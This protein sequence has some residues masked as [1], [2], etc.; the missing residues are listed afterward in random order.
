MPV[1][2]AIGEIIMRGGNQL[3]IEKQA[4]KEGVLDLRQ[5]GLKKVREGVTS[6]E[7]VENVTNQ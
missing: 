5:S 3:D 1:S 4:Q 7:E 6:L 2:E